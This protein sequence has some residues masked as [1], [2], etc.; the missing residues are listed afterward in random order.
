MVKS[1]TTRFL[2]ICYY[3]SARSG[4]VS[5]RLKTLSLCC[6]NLLL[7]MREEGGG[8]RAVPENEDLRCHDGHETICAGGSMNIYLVCYAN[9]SA[10]GGLPCSVFSTYEQ[11]KEECQRLA[12]KSMEHSIEYWKSLHEKEKIGSIPDFF[13]KETSKGIC[14]CRRFKG[15]RSLVFVVEKDVYYVKSFEVDKPSQC[16]WW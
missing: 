13:L 1:W 16:E 12:K 14:V 5:N 10:D 3:P 11:A 15:R 2:R 8:D 7:G 6:L 9:Y 4:I